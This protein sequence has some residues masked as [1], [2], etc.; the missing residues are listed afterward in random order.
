[1]LAYVFWHRP[2]EGA[3]AEDYERALET[4]P[5][6][7]GPPPAGG[8]A[9]ARR[10]YRLA[11][12][13]VARRATAR[14]EDAAATR[15][16][17]CSRT[18][19]RS[20][21]ST[22]PPSGAGTAA[23]TTASPRSRAPAPAAS[24]RCSRASRRRRAGR[25]Q[26]G[27]LGDSRRSRRPQR[28][29]GCGLAELLGDGMER[30]SARASGGASSCSARR[31]SSACWGPSSRRACARAGCRAA[32]ARASSRAS[33]SWS[34]SE[35]A[36]A[37]RYTRAASSRLALGWS[38]PPG[39]GEQ[40]PPR[41]WAPSTSIDDPR[42]PKE[43]GAPMTTSPTTEQQTLRDP[44]RAEAAPTAASAAGPR[45]CAREALARLA[46][47]G[48]ALMGTSHRQKPVQ[49]A[50]RRDPRRLRELFCAARRLRG[51]ARQRRRD[52]VLGRGRVR[53]GAR[54]RAAPDLRRVLAE[55]RD[56]HR[57]ARRSSPTRIVSPPIPATRPTRRRRRAGADGDADVIAWAHNETST[58][59][60][61]PGA[62]PAGAA[63]RAG[64]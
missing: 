43:R 49:G 40:P 58:G 42:G 45:R 10:R 21:C 22:R 64:R 37:V 34:A 38:S 16:G 35:R 14:A 1:M 17:T 20:A 12:A 9:A 31:P 44:R 11:R 5:P 18:T 30:A 28:R 6:L 2:R 19:P 61:V 23:A 52:R 29:A 7:A 50:R 8:D 57:A 63:R 36:A 59:V 54:A 33:R 51:R 4:L 56:R 41:A 39:S 48:A 55:V 24:T 47:D 25:R 53:A 46:G 3:P 32:G 13:A 26:R 15:T 27:G 62:P 60:M